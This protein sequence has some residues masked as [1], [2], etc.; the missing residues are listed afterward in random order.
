L[1]YELVHLIHGQRSSNILEMLDEA[2]ARRFRQQWRST[3]LLAADQARVHRAQSRISFWRNGDMLQPRQC[4]ANHASEKG[5]LIRSS[6]LTHEEA[7]KAVLFAASFTDLNIVEAAIDREYSRFTFTHRSEEDLQEH[8]AITFEY[9]DDLQI[10]YDGKVALVR[11]SIEL[12]KEEQT[13]IAA[14]RSEQF[15]ELYPFSEEEEAYGIA[16]LVSSVTGKSLVPIETKQHDVVL[17]KHKDEVLGSALIPTNRE[18]VVKLQQI[19]YLPDNV[20]IVDKKMDD[21]S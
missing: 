21:N 17:F 1:K 5:T 20:L 14:D 2:K 15:W 9:G 8:P 18:P 11:S 3:R 12:V 19:Q 4:G 16:E 10:A 7:T 6:P 13:K